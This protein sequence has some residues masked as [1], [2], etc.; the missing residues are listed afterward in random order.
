MLIIKIGINNDHKI[1]KINLRDY[2]TWSY[3]AFYDWQ[4]THTHGC[5]DNSLYYPPPVQS[6]FVVEEF[7]LV[8]TNI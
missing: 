2:S 6:I 8:F 3:W 1:N 4:L 5:S 7:E